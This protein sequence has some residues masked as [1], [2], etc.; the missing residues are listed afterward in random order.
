[1]RGLVK[2]TLRF[3]PLLAAVLMLSLPAGLEALVQ[4]G[5]SGGAPSLRPYVHVFVAYGIAWAL[6]FGWA[7]SIFRKL[8]RVEAQLHERDSSG[9]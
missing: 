4:E 1:M 9:V 6:V 3:S 5:A 2:S 8:G 7:V